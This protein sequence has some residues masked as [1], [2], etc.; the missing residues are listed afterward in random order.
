MRLTIKNKLYLGFASII[1]VTM[2]IGFFNL[3][4]DREV[5]NIQHRITDLRTP[6]IIAGL[7]IKDGIHLSLAGLRGYMILGGDPTK[8]EIFTAE[9]QKGWNT[10][11]A[12][13]TQFEAF[14]E[15]W[16]DP[17]N[18]QHL[19]EIKQL[20]T[21]F[22]IAQEEIEVIAHQDINV[23]SFHLLITEAAPKASRVINALTEMIDLESNLAATSQ[24]KNLLK[25]LADSRGS[26]AIGLANIRAF[27]L[28]G[29]IKFK[30]VFLQKWNVNQ[31]RFIQ[32]SKLEHLLSGNQIKAWETYKTYRTEFSPLPE[33]MF[34]LRLASDWNQANHWLSTKAAPKAKRILALL[35]IMEKSQNQLSIDDNT[36]LEKISNKMIFTMIVG[37]IACI[38]LSIFIAGTVSKAITKP[39]A[40]IVNRSK[41]IALGDLTGKPLLANGN[42]ELT[43][44]TVSVNKMS[45][46]LRDII[47][48]V[49]ISSNELIEAA[50]NLSD[51]ASKTSRGME[52]QQHTT[53]NVATAMNEMTA[54]VQ[55]VSSNAAE[56][57]TST[58]EADAKTE[59][60]KSVV[61][62]NKQNIQNLSDSIRNA[63]SLINKLGE[64]TN[65]VDTIVAVINGIAEQTNLLALNAAIE[66]ARAGEQGRGFAVVADEV[67]T[68][69]ARTQESTEEIRSVLESLK[70][71]ANDAMDAMEEGRKMADSSVERAS[72]AAESLEA[73][74]QSVAAINNMN[75]KIAAAAKEQNDV[76]E[77]LNRNIIE[78]NNEAETTVN[79]THETTAAA[80]QVNDIV[81]SLNKK[82]SH[83]KI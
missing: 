72:I 42:D 14:S 27:L 79:N 8:A 28:T 35:E 78:I 29:D 61:D 37:M 46:N 54:T 3:A 81:S 43:D 11:N 48:H 83:F 40:N 66:A 47:G 24:R 38:A 12:S 49:S 15:N 17:S 68:L 25:L 1:A 45:V 69:A 41:S 33:K 26:F 2:I 19:N 9:R 52:S 70:K 39:L 77:E 21:E 73:I 60:G 71:G 31:E 5:S 23:P 36:L 18:I 22:R 7:N 80:N 62:Q 58:K 20:L 75:T 82:I 30:D 59:S 32:I 6:T 16:T 57:A 55:E 51:V 64:D 53:Q 67:R 34:N 4:Q 56:A 10:I 50:N 74:S 65:G 13:I 76:T 44:L 63:S